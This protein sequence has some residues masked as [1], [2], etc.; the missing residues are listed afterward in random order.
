MPKP[1]RRDGCSRHSARASWRLELLV[2]DEAGRVDPGRRR[3]RVRSLAEDHAAQL[4]HALARGG[5]GGRRGGRALLGDVPAGEDDDRFG[6]QRRG[7]GHWPAVGARQH[8]HLAA[9]AGRAQPRRRHPRPREGVLAHAQAQ[10]LH[11]PADAPADRAEVVTPVLAA[12]ELVPV[13]DKPIA[14]ERPGQRQRQ[15]RE[16]GERGRVDDVIAAA[17]SQRVP[18]HAG[19][20]D[21]RREDAPLARARVQAHARAGRDHAHTRQVGL[22]VPLAQRDVGDVVAVGGEPQRQLAV[23]ALGAADGVREQAVVDDTDVQRKASTQSYVRPS[24]SSRACEA[25]TRT[26]GGCS[27]SDSA[28]GPIGSWLSAEPRPAPQPRS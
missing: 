6:G 14:A 3:R 23:P 21:Q 28:T 24:H 25:G 7:C 4:R 11:E 26:S 9:R 20:E 10:A 1:S 12:P 15:E 13:D 27:S 22:V 18:Q 5:D 19:A 17:V 16:V 8:R 2:R